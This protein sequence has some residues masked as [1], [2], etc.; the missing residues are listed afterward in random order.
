MN[1]RKSILCLFLLFLLSLGSLSVN[2]QTVSKVF[3]EQTLKTVLKEIESQTGL[4]IIYQKNEINENKKVNATFENT[5]VVEALSSILDQSLEVNLKNKMIVI[6]L[7]KLMPGDDK[8]KVKSITGKILDENGESVIGASVAV[9]GTTLGSITNIDGEYTLANVPENAEVTISFIGYQTLTF[10]ANDKALQNITLKEDSEMLDEVVVVGYGVQRKRDVTTSISSMKA[11]E[12]GVPVSSVDQALVGK[13]SGVQVSQPNGIPGG[14]LSIKVRGSGSITAGTEPLYVVDGF[15]MSGEAGN[16]TGQN[17]SPLSSINMNDIESIEVLKDASAA[18][19]YGS[20]GANGVVIITTKQGKEGKDMKP[21]VQYDGYV[22]FQQRTKKIDMLDAYEYAWLS[23]DGHNNAYLDL[24]ESKGIEGSINDSNEVRNQ[25]LGKKPDVINQAYLLPP[26]IMPYINGETG[27]TNTD[28]QDEVMRTGIVTSHNLS[29]SG[30]NKAARYF[31]SGNYMKEQGIVIGSD[32][33]QMGAR[34]KVDANY[35]KFTFGTNLSFNYSV[36][37]IVPTEDRY[38]EETIVASALAMSPTMPVYNADGSYNFDQWNWQDKHPQIV[39]PVALANEKEDQMKRYRFMG[40]VYGEYELYKNLKLKTSFGVDFNSYSS[41]YYRPSTLPTSLDRLPPSVPEGSKRDK[42]MLNWVWENTLS[43]TTIIKDV[44]NLSAIAGWTA[45]K[46]SVNT[47]LLAGNGYPND[48]VHTMN[49]ASAITKWSATAYEWSLLSALARVQYSYKGKYLLSAARMDG[50]SRFGKNNRW[51]MFPSASAGWYISEEDFM[52]DIKWLTSLKLR[53]S[54]GISGNFNIGNYEYYATLSEDNYVFG[55]ADGTLASGLRPA[56]AGNPDLGWEKTAMFNLGLE[57]GLFNMLTLE[58]DLYNSNTTDM[59]LN[60]PVAEFSGFS[61][62]PMN[63][64]KVNNK[65]VEFAISTTNTWG[66]F[67]WNN[68]FNISANRNEV[69]NLGGVDEMI[70]TSESVTFITKVGEPIGNYYTLVTDGVFANQAEIDNSKNP[71]K[72]QRKYAYVKGA[73]PGDFR[74]KDMDGNMEIDENDRTITGNYMPKF[75]YG[76]STELKYKWFDLSIA[77][78]GVQGNKIANIFRRYIDNM[79]GGNNCQVDALDRWQSESNPGSG[80][81]VRAN[82][83]AT[84][85]NG[86]TSTW[87]IE[88]GSY[89]R[90]KNITFGYTLPKSLLTNVGISR[91]RVYFST[92]NPFTF[93]KYSGYNPE[94]NMKGGSLTPGID[95]GTYPLSKSFVFGLNVTF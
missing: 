72:S 41:S 83:S 2:A 42:N 25:K 79:E 59:L 34:G 48:L 20:R 38:K 68:R 33:E 87:H 49:A 61:T 50:S 27:L 77:L 56:T 30:G 8:T 55:K 52:K 19:I 66:D 26:E 86:T 32:F 11:S 35:K 53:A 60:V 39:N 82:R 44:H 6:S 64:G 1:N 62:V 70:T 23:Y 5:P 16:G 71:D 24:L 81:V 45:Q 47:S 67:T 28:W 80:Y 31:I 12:L 51:G 73:K 9:Q 7:K 84:G 37:N 15:P 22:G 94:V 21:T 65:G 36:Y 63:I 54:Y 85:M 40:N 75:T 57:I 78:Q 46:E 90:I 89:M 93:T 76:F 91:A 10:K 95:Y 17:V 13:M 58:L 88:D 14:G 43:Y 69:K 18:A 3:K 4:S 92:Q 74:F 29:L